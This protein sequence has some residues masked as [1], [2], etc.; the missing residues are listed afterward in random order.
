MSEHRTLA[1]IA[2]AEQ[3]ETLAAIEAAGLPTESASNASRVNNTDVA[4]TDSQGVPESLA[5]RAVPDVSYGQATYEAYESYDPTD[6]LHAVEA[7]RSR[8][9][10]E[11]TRR[12][13]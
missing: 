3:I 6:P 12:D 5:R 13:W 11:Y 10:V 7:E 9:T 8:A 2:R 1:Q 4:G